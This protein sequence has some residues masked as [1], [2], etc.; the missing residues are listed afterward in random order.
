MKTITESGMIFG[1]F[2]DGEIFHIEQSNLYQFL[3]K[4][5]KSIE[6]IYSPQKNVIL[7]V[8]AKSSSPRL[9]NNIDFDGF[10]S[11]ISNK[12]IHSLELYIS[13]YIG[14]HGDKKQEIP[15]MFAKIDWEDAKIKFL[16]VINGHKEEWLLPIIDGLNRV[17]L[18]Q[19][20]IWNMEIA[21]A[22]ETIATELH[23]G[24]PEKFA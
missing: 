13:A 23:L 5:V 22:N 14:I 17:M 21:V 10:I 12:L 15:D 18:P 6:F 7:F 3:A 16:L 8:E 11:D 20:K 1:P 9:D 19:K 24:T 4:G 2:D